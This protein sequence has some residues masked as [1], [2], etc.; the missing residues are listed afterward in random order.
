MVRR[1]AA[2][3]PPACARKQPEAQAG[4]RRLGGEEGL[5]RTRQDGRGHP[6]ALVADRHPHRA[7]VGFHLEPHRL[8]RP[9][10][11]ERVAH[12]AG[13]GAGNR[14]ARQRR[15]RR[16]RQPFHAHARRVVGRQRVEDVTHEAVDGDHDRR[17]AGRL[18]GI[19]RHLIEYPPAALDLGADQPGILAQRRGAG[20]LARERTLELGG[21]DGDSAERRRQ[22]V[23]RACRQR[24]ERREALRARRLLAHG[25]DLG[26]AAF[27]RRR[28]TD[29]EVGRQQRRHDE[30]HQH[31]PEMERERALVVDVREGAARGQEEEARSRP[32][33]DQRATTSIPRRARRRRA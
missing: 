18:A 27:D 22:L 15:G 14:P 7:L 16:E 3:P 4:A 32:P 11:V 33:R 13:D 28:Q 29:H 5:D 30:R 9:R 24:R 8:D 6:G 26:V 23:C 21:R 31:T 20:V 10:R 19:A 12:Q 25:G 1:L 2:A 17:L